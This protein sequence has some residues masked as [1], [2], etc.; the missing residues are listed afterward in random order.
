MK[1]LI[2]NHFPLSGSGSG[3]YVKNI[4]NA[5]VRKGHEV[6]IIFPE[7][8]T[9][10]I[11]LENIKTHSVY[12]KDIEQIEGQ[13]DFNFPCFSIHPRSSHR[14]RHTS[15]EE[16]KLYEHAFKE[17]IEEEIKKFK[18]DLIHAQ[19]LGVI[20]AIAGRYDIPIITT[21]HGSELIEYAEV[22]SL[23]KYGREAFECS[24]KVIAVS[25]HSEK[26]IDKTFGL[27]KTIMIPNGYDSEVF[28]K[29]LDSKEE[30]LKGFGI[31]KQYNKIVG[32][33]GKL[34]LNKGIDILL[35]A[36][37][38][39]EKN[40][41]LTLIAGNGNQY[42][43]LKKLKKALGL[44]NVVFVGEQ[45][46]ESLRRIYTISDVSVV[47]SRQEAFGLVALEAIAC[48]TPVIASNEG[49]LPDFI[50]EQVGILVEKEKSEKFAEAIINV[51]GN[52][53]EFNSQYLQKYALENYSQE[54]LIDKLIR[55]YEE[56]R[57]I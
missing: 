43:E 5:L 2:T 46:Q 41:I 32:F 27:G 7:N 47:P 20:T 22:P 44:E 45:T 55:G 4:A 9:K 34:T 31:Q 25:K 28:Y 37:K 26:D 56:I 13:M 40:N 6:C 3:I 21:C 29:D 24:K 11:I 17:A 42:E 50:T 12:F 36:A 38:I 49:G 39:Y 33:A 18:P 57:L 15:V 51:L 19:H 8:S 10:H 48:G 54:L 1:I 52:E 30:V 35:K 16:M 14:F 53:K 23:L